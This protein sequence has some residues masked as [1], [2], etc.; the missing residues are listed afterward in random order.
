MIDALQTRANEF[1]G[2]E[3]RKQTQVLYSSSNVRTTHEQIRREMSQKKD[4]QKKMLESELFNIKEKPVAPMVPPTRYMTGLS[5]KF[6]TPGSSVSTSKI[7]DDLFLYFC[8]FMTS[9]RSRQ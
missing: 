6:C 2:T 8:T 5:C 7:F 4:R 3:T 9:A 1:W